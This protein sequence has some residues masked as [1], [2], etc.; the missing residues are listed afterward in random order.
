MLRKCKIYHCICLQTNIHTESRDVSC[1]V[2]SV[3]SSTLPQP[4]QAVP[5]ELP[6]SP[7]HPPPY[8]GNQAEKHNPVS[9]QTVTK[10]SE[11]TLPSKSPQNNVRAS[12]LEEIQAVQ[13]RRCWEE[14]AETGENY[15]ESNKP[16]FTSIGSS[17]KNGGASA[18]QDQLK[19]KLEARKR[20]LEAAEQMDANDSFS[21]N[22]Q[23][24]QV[25]DVQSTP[26]STSYK[27]L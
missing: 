22:V 3:T 9:E 15:K 21:S 16:D 13:A 7:T 11:Q 17:V 14:S 1:V 12:L 6:D 4:T 5:V 2:T 23:E 18:F 19:S 20:S 26:Q 25:S 27:G 24:P 10:E 8:P